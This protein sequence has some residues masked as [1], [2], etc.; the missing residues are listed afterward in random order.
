MTSHFVQGRTGSGSRTGTFETGIIVAMA[1]WCDALYGGVSLNEAFAGLVTGFG[2]E[3]GMLVRTHVTDFRP[4]RIAVWDRRGAAATAP[5]TTSFADAFFGR[6][7]A[8]PR[9]TSDWLASTYEHSVGET[10]DPALSN[11]QTK[12]G[13]TEYAALVLAGGPP[14]RD[15]IELHFTNPLTDTMQAA[16]TAVLPTMART[17]AS[18][19]VGLITRTVVNHHAPREASMRQTVKGSLLGTANPARLSRAEFRVCML[20]SRGLS[21]LG[22][23]EELAV[24]ESTVR[25]HLRSIYA[26]TDTSSLAEL[27][28]QLLSAAPP[29]EMPDSQCA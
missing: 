13:L 3:A 21:V 20:L 7:F 17:W 18:R 11:W 1:E 29:G 10:P 12:R 19:Q 6:L 23:A 8:R 9:A 14:V 15:H 22:V 28:F 5:L 24:C 25:S 4:A 26:K 27:V 16:I 2:A